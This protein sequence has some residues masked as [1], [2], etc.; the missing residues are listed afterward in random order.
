MPVEIP[1]A[2]LAKAAR[3]DDWADWMQALPRLVRDLL[4]EWALVVDGPPVHGDCAVVLP[5]QTAD[6]VAAA[7]KVGWPHW[8]AEHEHLALRHWAGNGAV[9]LL[10]ADPRRGALLLE[11]LELADLTTVPVLDACEVIAGLYARLH[12]PAPPQLVRLS[13]VSQR[14]A[15][16][17]E[18]LPVAGPLPRRYVEQAASLLRGFA[19]DPMTDGRLVHTDLHQLNVLAAAREPW[20]AID[21]KPMSGDPHYEVAPVLWNQWDEVLAAPPLRTAV[22]ARFHCL[23]D[24][25]GL[26]EERARDWVVARMMVNA[27][28]T[29]HEGDAAT[30]EGAEWI[31]ICVAVAK[32]VQD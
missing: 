13:E 1:A 23:V 28:W 29:V 25:A 4:G 6:G 20:L 18:A 7:L 5:V 3:S 12:V 22:R 26:V 14:W 31:T 16:E 2:F 32:A 30:P 8:E 15:R 17:L 24:A 21:P 11:R 9:R 10:R 27:M 19:S